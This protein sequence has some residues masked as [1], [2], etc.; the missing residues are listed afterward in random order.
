MKI[1][2]SQQ[3]YIIKLLKLYS[4]K[5]RVVKS[6]KFDEVDQNL[7]NKLTHFATVLSDALYSKI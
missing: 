7:K 2:T 4:P 6:K 1:Y 5:C 3:V